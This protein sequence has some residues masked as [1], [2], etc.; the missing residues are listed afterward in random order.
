L[1]HARSKPRGSMAPGCKNFAPVTI[2]TWDSDLD[3][4]SSSNR[5]YRIIDVHALHNPGCEALYATDTCS[6]T[7]SPHLYR[8]YF[9]SDSLMQGNHKQR[10]PNLRRAPACSSGLAQAS[11]FSWL[12][13]NANYSRRT[14]HQ[15]G[16][17]DGENPVCIKPIT[18]RLE[19][20]CF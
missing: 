5:L 4:I 16:D 13:T 20:G 6:A 19:A 7:G 8:Q 14:A 1:T 15:G 2:S 9:Q 18:M 3:L 12:A 10:Y 11:H 17:P